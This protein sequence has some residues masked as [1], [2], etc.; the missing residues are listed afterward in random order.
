[1]FPSDSH[2]LI[3]E[4]SMALRTLIKRNLGNLGFKNVIEAEDGIDALEKLKSIY[5]E[6][7]QV[8]LIISDW[9]MPNMSGIDLLVKVK[10]NPQFERIPFL[11]CTCESEISLVTLAISN[12]ADDYIIKPVSEESLSERMCA[13]WDRLQNGT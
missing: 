13:I 11:M 2:L 9:N 8:S 12:G 10:S 7:K 4:D 1:M 6:G 5:A 3:V